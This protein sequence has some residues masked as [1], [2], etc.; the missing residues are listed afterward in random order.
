MTHHLRQLR[1]EAGVSQETL[2]AAIGRRRTAIAKVEA[3]TRRLTVEEFF[4]IV[5]ALKLP[6]QSVVE[7][8]RRFAGLAKDEV[9]Q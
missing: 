5:E 2:A 7:W 6:P 9:A 3:G 4:L 8:G 1:D